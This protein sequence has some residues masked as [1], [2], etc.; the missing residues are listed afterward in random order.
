M[1]F[2]ATQCFNAAFRAFLTA[3]AMSD[4]RVQEIA[5][6][7]IERHTAVNAPAMMPLLFFSGKDGVPVYKGNKDDALPLSVVA[8]DTEAAKIGH[9]ALA[10]RLRHPAGPCAYFVQ[11]SD[12]FGIWMDPQAPHPAF[13]ELLKGTESMSA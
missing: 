2:G 8:C 6:V 9:P 11:T 5:N 12:Q 10:L 13:A 4:D 7:Q 1:I 3:A